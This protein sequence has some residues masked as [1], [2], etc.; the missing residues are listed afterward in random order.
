MV[1]VGLK[2]ILAVFFVPIWALGIKDDKRMVK[3]PLRIPSISSKLVRN[4][5]KPQMEYDSYSMNQ[6]L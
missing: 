3:I 2:Q 5:N 6:A 1:F 4:E